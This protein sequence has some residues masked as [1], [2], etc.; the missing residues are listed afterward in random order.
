MFP[1]LGQLKDVVFSKLFVG[2]SFFSKLAS[3]RD[4]TYS[5]SELYILQPM[6]GLAQPAHQVL[7]GAGKSLHQNENEMEMSVS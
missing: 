5:I 3:T 4:S 1:H 7:Q 2:C 6:K